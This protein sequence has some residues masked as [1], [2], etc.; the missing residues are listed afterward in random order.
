MI[1]FS[2]FGF[3]STSYANLT[4]DLTLQSETVYL[5]D[6]FT[7]L[8]GLR[9]DPDFSWSEDWIRVRVTK[10][11]GENELPLDNA[12][13]T[14]RRWPYRASE[15]ALP[16]QPQGNGTYFIPSVP[17][18]FRIYVITITDQ[19]GIIVLAAVLMI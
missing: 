17:G 9:A 16:V 12:N 3:P 14:V 7:A 10:L 19:S 15:P 2:L 4:L 11:F 8:V 13:V 6:N 18:G 5:H 1:I